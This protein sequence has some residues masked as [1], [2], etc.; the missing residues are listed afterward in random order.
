M[1]KPGWSH[2]GNTKIIEELQKIVARDSWIIEGWIAP[3]ARK[4]VFDRASTILYLDYPRL[5]IT[6]RYIK[7]W[8]KHRKEPRPELSGSP[9]KF[10]FKFLWLVFTKGEAISIN[11]SLGELADR[12]KLITISSPNIA[13][14]ILKR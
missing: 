4:L 12:S 14:H 3:S 10:S 1:W 7:R 13:S 2:V 9:E 11:K 5:L 8:F 6:W